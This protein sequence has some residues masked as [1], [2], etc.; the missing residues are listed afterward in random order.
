MLYPSDPGTLPPP[1][2][3]DGSRAP[4]VAAS[5][6]AADRALLLR[7]QRQALRYFLDNQLPDGLVLDRQHNRGPRAPAGLCSTSATGMGLIAVALAA[8]EPYRLLTPKAAAAR[9]GA[10][11]AAALERLPSDHGMLPHFVHSTTG[12]VYGRDAFSTVDTAWLLAGALWAAAFLRDARLEALAARLYGRADWHYWTAPTLPGSAGLVQHG[13]GSDG[14]FLGCTWDRLNGETVFLYVL[15]AGAAGRRAIPPAGWAALRPFYGT[16]GGLRFNNADLGLFVFQYGLDLLDLGSWESPGG[17]DLAAEARL[18]TRANRQV[19][20]DAADRFATYRTF[21]GLS[22]G[23]GPSEAG[24]ADAYR[25]YAPGRPL[26]GSAHLTATLAS[27]AHEPEAVLENL[28]EGERHRQGLARG[29]YG[30]GSVNVD[31]NWVARDMV[32][33]DAGAAV[34]ALDNYLMA[35]R[36]RAVFHGLACVQEGLR[37]LGFVPRRAPGDPAPD[38]AA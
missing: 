4:A 34:L 2:C 27:V 5:L 33:I 20:R 18:A 25:C 38:L 15:A 6:P 31:R 9:V 37:R 7:L 29:R 30:L 32:G 35:S 16:A 26:D 23:D 14:R 11:L 13:K 1:D 19:C 24:G 36:V 10:A 22:A 8:A 21:W 3:R 12:A 28:R 17:V